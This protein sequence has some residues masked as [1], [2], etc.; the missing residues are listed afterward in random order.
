[1]IKAMMHKISIGMLISLML[2]ARS[3][4]MFDVTFTDGELTINGQNV[5]KPQGIVRGLGNFVFSAVGGLF[6]CKLALNHYCYTGYQRQGIT[7]VGQLAGSAIFDV[8]N[9]VVSGNNFTKPVLTK[10]VSCVGAL[11]S[12]KVAQDYKTGG[13]DTKKF[14]KDPVAFGAHLGEIAVPFGYG[15]HAESAINLG[16]ACGEQIGIH[17]FLNKKDKKAKNPGTLCFGPQGEWQKEKWQKKIKGEQKKA[18]GKA[19]GA[20]LGGALAAH[21]LQEPSLR[22]AFLKKGFIEAAVTQTINKYVAPCSAFLANH[23]ISAMHDVHHDGSGQEKNDKQRMMYNMLN[24]AL[25]GSAS[26]YLYSKIS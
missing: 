22:D 17:L 21:V 16:R 6:A 3:S 26:N 15:N 10:A 7:T 11:L 18:M 2:F 12:Q 9:G 24:G 23:T 13:L 19:I 1:M 20:H 14:I 8:V 4:A 25:V 5:K